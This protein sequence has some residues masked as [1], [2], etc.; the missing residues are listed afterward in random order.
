MEHFSKK[1][2]DNVILKKTLRILKNYQI[3]RQAAKI[4]DLKM[5]S[6]YRKNLLKKAFFPWRTY[7]FE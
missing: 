4:R 7:Y 3:E 1:Y 6:V 2:R 5:D